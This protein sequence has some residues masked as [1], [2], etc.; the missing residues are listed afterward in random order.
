MQEIQNHI[1]DP[2][3]LPI[4][5]LHCRNMELRAFCSCN[6]DI[7]PMTFIHELELYPL[8]MYQQTNNE[9]ST[10]MLSKLSFYAE[11][12]RCHGKLS[13]R[14]LQKFRL[15]LPRSMARVA[16]ANLGK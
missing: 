14:G 7:D 3:L 8:E 13:A 9:L 4:E 11:L 12:D 1:F 5:V 16:C 10:T 6:L 15:T 2:E